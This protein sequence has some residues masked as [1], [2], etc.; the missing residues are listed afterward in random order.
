MPGNHESAFRKLGTCQCF[1]NFVNGRNRCT[2]E[3][4]GVVIELYTD[5]NFRLT[6]RYGREALAIIGRKGTCGPIA[7]RLGQGNLAGSLLGV[8]M[9]RAEA[10]SYNWLCSKFVE[11][12]IR[13]W[14]ECVENFIRRCQAPGL[15]IVAAG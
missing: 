9:R 7:Q 3:S 10:P 15:R 12:I 14:C 6:C 4:V 8:C 2:S 5:I 1:A 11:N 13:F